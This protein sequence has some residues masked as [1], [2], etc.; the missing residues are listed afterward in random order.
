MSDGA[1]QTDIVGI[2]V[3]AALT[4]E[5]I[6]DQRAFLPMLA[7]LLKESLPDQVQC[8]ESGLFKKTIHGIVVTSGENRLTLEDTGRGPISASFTRVVRGIALKT[9]SLQI[10]EWLVLLAEVLEESATHNAQARTALARTLG[11]D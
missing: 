10:E 2:G 5:F 1:S 9:E 8:L 7:R 6:A 4:K 3:A 11:L